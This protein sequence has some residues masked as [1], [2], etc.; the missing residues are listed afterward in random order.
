MYNQHKT[1]KLLIAKLF[2]SK[3]VQFP[4]LQIVLAFLNNVEMN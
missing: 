1:N 2:N 4:D 3:L